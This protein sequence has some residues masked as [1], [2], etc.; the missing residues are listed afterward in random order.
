MNL[1]IKG[2]KIK[3]LSSNLKGHVVLILELCFEFIEILLH[4]QR[5]NRIAIQ[6]LF[7]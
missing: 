6:P 3:Q 1:C 2:M 5:L 4:K 7:M